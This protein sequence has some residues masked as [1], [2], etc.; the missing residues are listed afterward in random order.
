M[1]GKKSVKNSSANSGKVIANSDKDN[2][3]NSGKGKNKKGNKEIYYLINNITA[4]MIDNMK[5]AISDLDEDLN[6]LRKLKGELD[7]LEKQGVSVRRLCDDLNSQ[8]NRIESKRESLKELQ[9]TMYNDIYNILYNKMY[10]IST[11]SI[12]TIRDAGES[13]GVQ[14][15]KM[16]GGFTNDNNEPTD[17][18]HLKKHRD[19][20]CQLYN[21]DHCNEINNHLNKV[22]TGLQE[23]AGSIIKI[24]SKLDQN[25]KIGFNIGEYDDLIKMKER[26]DEFVNTVADEIVEDITTVMNGVGEKIN[27]F[28]EYTK[29]IKGKS[30][31]INV[32]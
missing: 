17:G 16:F 5:K 12:R 29:E 24:M 18:G 14:L 19:I 9:A 15:A 7:T 2:S 11:F 22:F 27:D 26:I 31:S 1:S 8:E 4:I 23:K 6:E 30:V 20:H 32:N 10:V 25:K 3:G 28:K 21:I 13:E